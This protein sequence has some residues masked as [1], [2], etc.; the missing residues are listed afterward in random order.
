MNVN[1]F[2]PK[3]YISESVF[4]M[5]IY[6][7]IAEIRT[8][9]DADDMVDEL[10]DRFGDPPKETLDLIEI[11]LIRG[12]AMKCGIF[13][14]KQ[15]D[16]GVVLKFKMPDDEMLRKLMVMAAANSKTLRFGKGEIPT[17][18]IRKGSVNQKDLLKYLKNLLKHLQSE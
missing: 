15:T 14:I 5:E 16:A 18:I 10:I 12:M 13:E 9:Q 2:I 4:I 7:K 1:A 17:V 6:R 11:A 8:R 3:N